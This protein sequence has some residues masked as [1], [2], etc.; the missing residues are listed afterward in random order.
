MEFHIKRAILNKGQNIDGYTISGL[1]GQGGY[2]DV[3]KVINSE[4]K[5]LAMK[6]EYLNAPKKST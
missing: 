3:Y 6:T 4:G 5:K 1:L 2:G